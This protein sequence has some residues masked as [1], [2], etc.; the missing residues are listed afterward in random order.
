MPTCEALRNS[1]ELVKTCPCVPDRIGIWTEVLVFEEKGKTGVPGA[2]PLGG[3]ERTNKKSTQIWFRRR[4]LKPGP[5][6]WETSALI[7]A[8]SLL[9][10]TLSLF[11]RSCDSHQPR[12][13][14][15][16]MKYPAQVSLQSI[17]ARFGDTKCLP[18]IFN[19][20]VCLYF[21]ARHQPKNSQDI[22]NQFDG[23]DS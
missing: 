20:S 21:A 1:Y 16:F 12:H 3:R 8:T 2:K 19:S 18:F 6:W 10:C 17:S 9:P 15:I 5:H 22:S 7:S 23:K 11:K 14:F 4:D 13:D